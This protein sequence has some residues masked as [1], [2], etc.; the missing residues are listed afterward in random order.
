MKG[1]LI[2]TIVKLNLIGSG[3][4]NMVFLGPFIHIDEVLKIAAPPIRGWSR[5]LKDDSAY[6]EISVT[7]EFNYGDLIYRD[8]HFLY[9]PAKGG[10]A[11]TLFWLDH[12]VHDW[13]ATQVPALRG[14][15]NPDASGKE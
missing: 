4:A 1:P 14:P 5:S 15:Q 9:S 10:A 2:A 7:I 8:I 13:L 3:A 11:T 12:G 6:G